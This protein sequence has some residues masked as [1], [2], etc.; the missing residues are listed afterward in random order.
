LKKT[1]VASSFLFPGYSQN[2]IFKVRAQAPVAAPWVFQ[3]LWDWL[4]SWLRWLRALAG[5]G[6]TAPGPPPLVVVAPG[7]FAIKCPSPLNVLKDT[8]DHS[9][10]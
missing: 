8:Y 10:Y 9:C 1:Y 2:P 5:G 4:L 7:E 3:P 6:G